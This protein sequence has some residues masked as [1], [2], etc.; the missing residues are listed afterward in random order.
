[1]ADYVIDGIFLTKR[2]TGIQRYAIEITKE[3]DKLIDDNTT[4]ELLLPEWYKGDFK[5]NNIKII[6]YGNHSQRIWEQI[7]LMRY[8]KKNRTKGIF[9]ENTIPVFYKKGYVA[10]HDIGLKVNPQ[11]FNTSL[12]GFLTVMYRKYMYRLIVNSDMQIITVSEFSKSEIL[13]HYNVN[14]SRIHVIYNAWQHIENIVEDENVIHRYSLEKYNYYFA[15]ATLAPNKNFKWIVEAAKNNPKKTF[16]I[17]GGGKIADVISKDYSQ[18]TNLKYL[19]YVS[20][21]E[22]KALM[23]YCEAFLFPTFY[24]GFGIPPLEAVAS[25]A[26]EIIIS[27]I[28]CLREIYDGFALYIDPSSVKSFSEITEQTI[29]SSKLLE[30]YS[31]KE[32]ANRLYRLLIG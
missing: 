25:G 3:L 32:S 31:W 15:M 17:A 18:L 19:G 6:K 20:D 16:V 2:I 30:K 14:E 24:E 13:K 28:P 12:K 10:L 4:I 26:K 29:D 1:M 5:L 22:A 9:F 7:D 8:L 23:K 21:E 27:D 11:L